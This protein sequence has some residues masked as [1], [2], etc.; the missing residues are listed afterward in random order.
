LQHHTAIK[1]TFLGTGTS[2]GVPLIG[3][4]CTQCTSVNKKDK[5]LRT[6]IKIESSTT[7]IV[8]DTTPDFRYQMLRTKTIK[9]DACV[10]THPHKDHL[11]GLDDVR[12]YNFFSNQ[13]M[14]L[15]AN[16]F[17][18]EAI[19]KELYYAFSD[20]QYPGVPKLQLHE[21]ND[22]C[23]T[24]GDITL[25]PIKV[26]HLNMPVVGFRI[27]DFT[28]ITDAN[29]I[30]EQELQKIVGSKILVLNALRRQPHI[31]HFT[32]Q[33]AIDLSIQL[34][35]PEVYFTHISHQ[36]GLHDEVNDELPSHIQ[37]AYDGLTLEV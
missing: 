26:W 27:G 15:Y 17:T 29:K 34:K 12:A 24:I 13:P 33:E 7:T 30:E 31:S 32:L 19:K 4:N 28:Y 2:S 9:L 5:R 11:G 21:F 6:S 16:S 23:F 35:I 3:C 14:P 25:Q 22:E 10:F 37:L 36:L 20:K 18:A 8:I 1:I